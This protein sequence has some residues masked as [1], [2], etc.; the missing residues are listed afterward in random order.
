MC[1]EQDKPDYFYCS[2]SGFKEINCLHEERELIWNKLT[3]FE[4]EIMRRF[5]IVNYGCCYFTITQ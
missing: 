1:F 2:Q 4:L 3:E 5:A